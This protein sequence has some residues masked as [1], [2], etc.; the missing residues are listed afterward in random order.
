MTASFVVR[1]HLHIKGRSEQLIQLER[2]VFSQTIE[3]P[4]SNQGQ[5]HKVIKM[6]LQRDGRFRNDRPKLPPNGFSLN[7]MDKSWIAS[8]SRKHKLWLA[9]LPSNGNEPRSKVRTSPEGVNEPDSCSARLA[10]GWHCGSSG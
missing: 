1:H 2:N 9:C 10:L 5:L 3:R 8:L 4:K 7:N 6:S